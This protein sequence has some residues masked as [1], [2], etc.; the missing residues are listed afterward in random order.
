MS[1]IS[2][3]Q[4]DTGEGDISEVQEAF[5]SYEKYIRTKDAFVTIV[6][7]MQY[8]EVTKKIKALLSS[9]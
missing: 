2:P 8:Q 5:T 7:D 1:L 6:K 3:F 4:Y 9:R